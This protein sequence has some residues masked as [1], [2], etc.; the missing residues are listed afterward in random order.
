MK[1]YLLDW[2]NSEQMLKKGKKYGKPGSWFEYNCFSDAYFTEQKQY[3]K[4]NEEIIS[5]TNNAM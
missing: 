4:K 2:P 3:M 5:E 1:K